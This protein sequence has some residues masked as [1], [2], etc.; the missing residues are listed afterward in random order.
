MMAAAG[1]SGGLQ[2]T[3]WIVAGAVVVVLGGVAFW[4]RPEAPRPPAPVTTPE[5][6]QAPTAGQAP[7]TQDVPADAPS[8]T[9]P[10]PLASAVEPEGTGS[11]A[12]GEA[13]EPAAAPE[14][15]ADAAAQPEAVATAPEARGAEADRPV[16][17]ADARAADAR[18]AGAPVL[19]L[20]RVDT[21][22][23]AVIAGKAPAGSRVTLLLDDEQLDSFEVDRTG[24]FA[25]FLDIPVGDTPRVLTAIAEH[26]GAQVPVA[27]PDHPCPGGR[28]RA[29]GR[30]C[31]GGAT[32]GQDRAERRGGNLLCP[33]QRRGR[34]SPG[35]RSGPT[36]GRC[37]RRGRRNDCA[38]RRCRRGATRSR[39]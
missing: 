22:G 24:S 17:A 9:V 6:T 33:G 27:R 37:R 18:D 30:A 16:E 32:A 4:F 23:S 36:T 35:I 12:A 39:T 13:A 26:D 28:G 15:E 14:S 34:R 10:E 31:P 2:K 29:G 1:G 38:I 3:G 25:R 20:V 11:K 19:D 7:A 21:D 5:A 8:D